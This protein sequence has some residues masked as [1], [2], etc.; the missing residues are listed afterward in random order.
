[1]SD[2]WI[3]VPLMA[4]RLT[5]ALPNEGG[6]LIPEYVVGLIYNDVT[7]VLIALTKAGDNRWI[8]PG[9]KHWH[10]EVMFRDSR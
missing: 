9:K 4:D 1:M 8:N 3:A 2:N 5:Y 10:L 7:N 6:D